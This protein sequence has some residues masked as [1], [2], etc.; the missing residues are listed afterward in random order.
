M[1]LKKVR[2]VSTRDGREYKVKKD[3]A[4]EQGKGAQ[5][6]GVSRWKEG[7]GRERAPKLIRVAKRIYKTSSRGKTR[8]TKRSHRRLSDPRT[9]GRQRVGRLP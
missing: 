1:R 4:T 7:E 9:S 5:K 6:E 3:I 8:G 2:C